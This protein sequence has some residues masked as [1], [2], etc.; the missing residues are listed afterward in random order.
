M[1]QGLPY[2]AFDDVAG[3]VVAPRMTRDHAAKRTSAQRLGQL[4]RL[5]LAA[6]LAVVLLGV[7]GCGGP[8]GELSER[9]C[10]SAGDQSQA[11]TSLQQLESSPHAGDRDACTAGL[12]YLD[13]LKRGR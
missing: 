4:S 12:A 3:A 8:C 7:F 2:R 11:C 5:V 6:L 9:V 1:P 10:A 13:E